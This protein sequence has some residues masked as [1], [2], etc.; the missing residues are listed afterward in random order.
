M[1]ISNSKTIY[2]VN[3]QIRDTKEILVTHKGYMNHITL[4]SRYSEIP[5]LCEVTEMNLHTFVILIEEIQG[6]KSFPG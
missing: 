4:M 5:S 1:K 2:R 3:L 6:Q